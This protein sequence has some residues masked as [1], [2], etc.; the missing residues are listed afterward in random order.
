MYTDLFET[1]TDRFSI[2]AD[3]FPICTDRF[4]I[5]MCR[6]AIRPTNPGTPLANQRLTECDLLLSTF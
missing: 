1:D 2:R 4:P 5:H 6:K 3:L